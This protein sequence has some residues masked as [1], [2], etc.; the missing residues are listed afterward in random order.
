MVNNICKALLLFMLLIFRSPSEAQGTWTRMTIPTT[1]YLRSV[2]FTDSLYGWAA[3]DSGT[4]L[5]TTNGGASWT[6]QG[7]QTSNEIEFVFFLNRNL[8]WASE[9]NYTTSPYGTTLLKT[10]NGGATWQ[11]TPFP[12]PD[13]FMTCILY[14]DSLTGWMGGKPN[15]IFKTTDGGASWTAA[16]IDTSVLAFFPVL[17]IEFYDQNYGYA[18]G[19]ILD[20]AGVI[21]RTD[22]GGDKW[23]AID[24]SY[25]PADE[26]HRLHLFDSL[27]VLGAGGD[28]DFGYGVGMIRTTNGG[29]SWTYD[30]LPIQGNAYDLDFRNYS[31]AWAPLGPKR[32]FIYSLDAGNTWTPILTPDSTAIYDVTFPDSLHGYAVGKNGAFLKYHPPVIPS[33]SPVPAEPDAC[34]LYQNY[35]NPAGSVTT[36][37]FTLP[38]AGSLMGHY[39]SQPFPAVR[40]IITDILGHEV[41]ALSPTGAL[42]GIH[43][44]TFDAS[45]LPGGFYLY[46]LQV[47]APGHPTTIAGPKRM[48]IIR[49]K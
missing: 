24:P 18:S 2:C 7:I 27:N 8:G 15:G 34:T 48:V 40:V 21:W 10:T 23:Y 42:P 39:G 22:N 30:E 33:V 29:L 14:T 37:K 43:E 19:G 6:S 32:K 45:G 5:H 49:E 13:I 26:V 41:A 25:A 9:F 12:V 44:V 36:I 38:S 28:P 1:Q 35:P 17:D 31:E 47:G 11:S 20:I 16:A 4:I 46:S 3:G